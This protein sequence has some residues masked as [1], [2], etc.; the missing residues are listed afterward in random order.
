MVHTYTT[1]V[2]KPSQPRHLYYAFGVLLASIVAVFTVPSVAG[3]SSGWTRVAVGVFFSIVGWLGI[4]D[5]RGATSHADYPP[6]GTSTLFTR[7]ATAKDP[8]FLRRA[9]QAL[10]AV[11]VA[12]GVVLILSAIVRFR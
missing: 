1:D 4:L 6:V 10:G 8:L 7:V 9:T 12:F 2:W 3:S 11:S 5:W